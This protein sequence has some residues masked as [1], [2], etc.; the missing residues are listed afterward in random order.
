MAIHVSTTTKC[1]RYAV[2]P[3]QGVGI[4][5]YGGSRWVWPTSV[6]GTCKGY[7]GSNNTVSLVCDNSSG[8][9]YRVGI[10]DQWQDRKH[11][12]YGGTD[13][14]CKFKLK[15]NTAPAGEYVALEHIESH[16]H[17]RPHWET[18]RNIAGYNV[19]GFLDAY[20]L[21][22]QMYENGEPTTPAA[23]ISEVPR[24]GDYVYRARIEAQRLQLEILTTS[25][26]FRCIKVQQKCMPIDKAYGPA[27]DVPQENIWQREF[28]T[29]YFWISRD[30]TSIGLN[31][32]KGTVATG[33]YDIKYQGPD[34]VPL[35]AI[36]F[37][38]ADG[39]HD[40]ISNLS[41]DF[42]LIAWIHG[43]AT[44]P[45]TI[46]RIT[47]GITT[48]NITMPAT[49]SLRWNDGTNDFVRALSWNGS[50]WV[51]IAVQKSGNMMR[52]YENGAQASA[53]ALMNAAMV[54]GGTASIG[55]SSIFTMFD[56]R[57]IPRA[58]SLGALSYMYDQVVNY[59]GKSL[60]P[61]PK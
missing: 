28:R 45:C 15:E 42:T 2:K 9:F 49:N 17:M 27:L 12:Q 59:N 1:Y 22:L 18:N 55:V 21:S 40:T 6:S 5:E 48:L 35:S 56:A 46:W 37:G 39:Y 19:D 53:Q 8:K 52:F 23:K 16:V 41:G 57:I 36:A 11:W 58:V 61:I 44:F 25:S 54:Y 10:A 31:R 50:G 30:K 51:M 24:Y 34:G 7:D 60:L 14:A 47:N 20:T 38:A 13:I 4:T 33:S 32:A 26:A 43:A 29:P 3:Q